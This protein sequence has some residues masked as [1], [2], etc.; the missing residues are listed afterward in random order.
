MRDRE[1]GVAFRFWVRVERERNDQ[2]M[3]KLGLWNAMKTRAGDGPTPARTTIDNLA[4]STR[5]PQ[6]RIVRALADALGIPWQEAQELAGLVP[7]ATSPTVD[8]RDAI[9]RSDLYTKQEK[10]ALLGLIDVFD[11]TRDRVGRRE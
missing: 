4:T 8:V 1:K 9:A 5:A 6:P 2:G 3:T 7:P 10:A 11:A